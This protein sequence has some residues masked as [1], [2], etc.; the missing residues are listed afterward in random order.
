M[1]LFIMI[2]ITFI[3]QCGGGEVL[4]YLGMLGRFHGDDHS[5]LDLRSNCQLGLYLDLIDPLFLQKINQFVP[6][7]I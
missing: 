2:L 6:F 3:A 4:L 1:F 5:F 7:C